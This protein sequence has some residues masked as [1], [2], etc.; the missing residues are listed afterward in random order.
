MKYQYAEDVD[1]IVHSSVKRACAVTT[2]RMAQTPMISGCTIQ[3][4]G[5]NPWIESTEKKEDKND[6]L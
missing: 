3:K 4:S 5:R 6:N 2:M 1:S